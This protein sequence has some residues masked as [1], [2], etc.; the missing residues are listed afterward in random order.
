M[1]TKKTAVAGN[2]TFD[3]WSA[4]GGT[5]IVQPGDI[6][7][8]VANRN[9]KPV[10]KYTGETKTLEV[11]E[12]WYASETVGS[13]ATNPNYYT[14]SSN[15]II[16][17][18]SGKYLTLM[19]NKESYAYVKIDLTGITAEN[20]S[21]AIL[22]VNY[23]KVRTSSRLK[24]ESVAEPAYNVAFHS[25]GTKTLPTVE[26]TAVYTSD[27]IATSTTAGTLATSDISTYI[28]GKL[29][30]GKK[31]VYLRI[32]WNDGGS[33]ATNGLQFNGATLTIETISD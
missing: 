18:T 21:S 3:G 16:A 20:L 25:V 15:A 4:D 10:W 32:S 13:A 12:T 8:V 7:T 19:K 17:Y 2:Y 26:G 27:S 24:V 29:V 23:D 30:E 6:V 28:K 22:N 9:Y 33:G 11:D 1:F 14:N 31:A 5:T